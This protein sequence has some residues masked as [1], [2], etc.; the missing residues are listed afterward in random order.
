MRAEQL[1][2]WLSNYIDAI[3]F[4]KELSY[5]CSCLP[6]RLLVPQKP[7][8]LEQAIGEYFAV[9]EAS[10]TAER[11]TKHYWYTNRQYLS[12]IASFLSS[13]C[14]KWPF[15]LFCDGQQ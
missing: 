15:F 2:M 12:C 11:A 9:V 7:N 14:L 3:W 13:S 6:T 10:N 4:I 1:I 8:R 5:R